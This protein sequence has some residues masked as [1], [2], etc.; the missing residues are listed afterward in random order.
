MSVSSSRSTTDRE[1]CASNHDPEMYSLWNRCLQGFGSLDTSNDYGDEC[2]ILHVKLKFE[3]LRTF[4]WG[5]PMHLVYTYP[6][7][8]EDFFLTHILNFTEV[9][10]TDAIRFLGDLR[11]FFENIDAL[12]TEYG[13]QQAPVTAVDA[14]LGVESWH[15]FG[16]ATSSI[17]KK[18]YGKIFSLAADEKQQATANKATRW[19]IGDKKKFLGMVAK[20]RYFNDRLCGLDSFLELAII[21]H[22]EACIDNAT[23][24]QALRL[25]QR[26]VIGDH[27]KVAEKV[28]TRLRELEA[29]GQF[30][31]TKVRLCRA[32]EDAVMVKDKLLLF[33]SKSDVS[34]RFED[35]ETDPRKY[36]FFPNE[37]SRR[38]AQLP[39]LP[40]LRAMGAGRFGCQFC[41]FL[42]LAIL[43]NCSD[44][45]KLCHQLE[46]KLHY[47]FNDV[48]D[49]VPFA[50]V[51]ELSP[52]SSSYPSRL[53][54][55]LAASGGGHAQSLGF[56][57]PIRDALDGRSLETLR[58]AISGTQDGRILDGLSDAATP[59]LPQTPTPRSDNMYL[60]TR[61]I[62]IDI[63]P[64]ASSPPTPSLRLVLGEDL[65]KRTSRAEKVQYAA[66]SY[67]WGTASEAAAQAVTGKETI[68]QRCSGIPEEE[69]TP[70]IRDAIEI[71]RTLNIR[72]IWVDALCII[73]RCLS[74]WETESL[75][76]AHIYG[77]AYL[78]ICPIA[79]SSCHEGF[80]KRNLTQ[81]LEIHFKSVRWPGVEQD[82]RLC[83]PLPVRAG[84]EVLN[85][86]RAQGA[87]SYSGW[88]KR[89]WTFQELLLSRQLLCFGSL[90]SYLVTPQSVITEFG[91]EEN[92][93]ATLGMALQDFGGEIKRQDD[94]AYKL[95]NLWMSL[96][97]EYSGRR[98]T[99]RKDILPALSSIAQLSSHLLDDEYKAGLWEKDLPEQ[100]LWTVDSEVDHGLESLLGFLA[101][102]ERDSGPSWS[103]SSR[104]ERTSY[105]RYR[106]EHEPA[107]GRW[108]IRE[109][110]RI[111]AQM[112]VHGENPF[113]VVSSGELRIWSVI[114]RVES[115]ILQNVQMHGK[116]WHVS[117]ADN[118]SLILHFDCV[119]S[120]S[121]LDV[122]EISLVKL[123]RLGMNV[124]EIARYHGWDEN[125][126]IHSDLRSDVDSTLSRHGLIICPCPNPP[127]KN[128]WFRIGTFVE[129]REDD[130]YDE[131]G[132]RRGFR[133][134][135]LV[136]GGVLGTVFII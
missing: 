55:P 132:N 126:T 123:G 5:V 101:D 110:P 97:G 94:Q 11:A 74:D 100:L 36:C 29:L 58:N 12:E 63:N 68:A 70:V 95:R 48:M 78:T 41:R 35:K 13:L 17:F 136:K 23:D 73:Q 134:G 92:L 59:Q 76:M 10:R 121:D 71:C 108:Y 9:S 131:F 57:P 135:S 103:W 1:G 26:A 52:T 51:A 91:D 42:R 75:K 24:I 115:K 102:P 120:R 80:L 86:F 77:G 61:L 39:D 99:S 96:V 3:M 109:A 125:D 124:D 98:F 69:L 4:V 114:K 81:N 105:E 6:V 119:V 106:S 16:S 43:E 79:S 37:S 127:R 15:G 118:T 33:E 93:Q 32:C 53:V 25:F 30:D 87:L 84:M 20:I 46:I 54:F 122:H 67:C 50:L 18:E 107:G 130:G 117:L 34:E 112:E 19:T 47:A 88:A 60:P 82:Y 113:G 56:E 45:H 7:D 8:S 128:V 85:P 89:G 104:P 64:A 65:A 72:Y 38:V 2:A 49:K 62:E 14:D 66:L 90:R 116:S 28:D 129:K 44:R 22:F 40:L 83:W 27:N 31:T 21:I 111:E 133:L